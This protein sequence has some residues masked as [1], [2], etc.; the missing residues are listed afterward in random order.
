MEFLSVW[1]ED[2]CS[3]PMA[4]NDDV[5]YTWRRRLDMEDELIIGDTPSIF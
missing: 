1:M 2:E 4:K 3:L 5:H